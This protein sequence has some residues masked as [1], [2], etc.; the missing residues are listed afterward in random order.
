MV[1]ISNTLRQLYL[2]HVRPTA[3]TLGSEIPHKQQ[4]KSTIFQPPVNVGFPNALNGIFGSEFGRSTAPKPTNLPPIQ[5]LYPLTTKGATLPDVQL[6][7]LTFKGTA[8]TFK[9]DQVSS[10]SS[11]GTM[12]N[13]T[14]YH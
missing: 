3:N 8:L 1:C 7:P 2:I 5:L 4:Q 14:V 13:T 11:S 6:S 10:E 9:R 12:I